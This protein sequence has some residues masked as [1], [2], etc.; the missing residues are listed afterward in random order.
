[1]LALHTTTLTVPPNGSPPMD[2]NLDEVLSLKF[3]PDSKC[4][5]TT[6]ESLTGSAFSTASIK[7]VHYTVDV[8]SAG[9]I[10]TVAVL[11][12]FNLKPPGS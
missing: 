12:V 8:F 5:S 6:S 1:M 11:G 4:L 2:T 10:Y 9:K 7:E 3:Q